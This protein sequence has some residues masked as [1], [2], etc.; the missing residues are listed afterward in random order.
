MSFYEVY[1]KFFYHHQFKRFVYYMCI[2]MH[3][4]VNIVI[5]LTP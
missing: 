4:F 1:S 3:I 5:F 2:Y